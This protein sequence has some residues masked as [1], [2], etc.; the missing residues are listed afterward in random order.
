MENNQV[1]MN[2]FYSGQIK[3]FESQISDG[4]LSC[5]RSGLENFMNTSPYFPQVISSVW[6]NEQVRLHLEFNCTFDIKNVILILREVSLTDE[7]NAKILELVK[8]REEPIHD[9]VSRALATLLK[10][11]SK[12]LVDAVAEMYRIVL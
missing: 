8:L 6:R 1:L 10:S 7:E 12:V 5:N 4:L 11:D 9:S 2:A 3:G